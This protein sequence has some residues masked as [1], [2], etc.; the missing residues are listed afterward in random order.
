M[1]VIDAGQASLPIS[2]AT[3]VS[4]CPEKGAIAVGMDVELDLEFFLSV[5]F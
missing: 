3:I 4:V 1:H 2:A 5:V